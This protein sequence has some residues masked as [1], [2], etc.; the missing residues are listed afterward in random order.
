M[1]AIKK[2][3]LNQATAPLAEYVEI[4]KEEPLLLLLNGKPV[5]ALVPLDEET[6]LETIAVSTDPD[7]LALIERSREKQKREGGLSTEEVRRKLGLA[8]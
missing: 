5:A 1:K 3:E 8:G 4:A 6:D 7:F 2:L